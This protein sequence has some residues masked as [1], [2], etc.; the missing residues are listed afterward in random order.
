MRKEQRK[1]QSVDA[2]V[3]QIAKL[4]Q[5]EGKELKDFERQALEKDE[6]RKARLLAKKHA[7][8]KDENEFWSEFFNTR[9][10]LINADGEMRHK[11]NNLNSILRR[12]D[13]S[14]SAR[15]KAIIESGQ[16]ERALA[17]LRN[18]QLPIISYAENMINRKRMNDILSESLEN[19]FPLHIKKFD[20]VANIIWAKGTYEEMLSAAS[21]LGTDVVGGLNSAYYAGIKSGKTKKEMAA[22][23]KNVMN[24]RYKAELDLDGLIYTNSAIIRRVCDNATRKINENLANLAT[25]EKT[26]GKAK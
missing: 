25:K 26:V 3:L 8:E 2:L 17:F 14:V 11:S 15:I 20:E 24:E 12:T 7:N 4:K 23:F 1:K 9:K 5:A 18:C 13:A 10:V 21:L 6:E 16:S 19:G 22:D